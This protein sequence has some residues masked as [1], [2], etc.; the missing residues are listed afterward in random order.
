MIGEKAHFFDPFLQGLGSTSAWGVKLADGIK[1]QPWPQA[2]NLLLI[3][4]PEPKE[5]PN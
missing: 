5:S 3:Q 4:E 1:Q 2:T